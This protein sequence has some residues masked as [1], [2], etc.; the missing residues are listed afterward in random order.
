MITLLGATEIGATDI[1]GASAA[2]LTPPQ[3]REAVVRL[4]NAFVGNDPQALDV[5]DPGQ[6]IQHNLRAEWKND[7]GKF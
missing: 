7:N 5:I 3:K 4:L 2:T 1:R 6:Y